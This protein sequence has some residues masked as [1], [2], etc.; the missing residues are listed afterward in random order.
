MTASWMKP[1]DEAAKDVRRQREECDLSELTLALD[2]APWFDRREVSD[3][4]A[5]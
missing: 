1:F 5:S 3:D 4:C 2:A